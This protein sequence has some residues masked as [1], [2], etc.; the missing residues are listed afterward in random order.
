[1]KKKN[2]SKKGEYEKRKYLFNCKSC[3]KSPKDKTKFVIK[4]FTKSRGVILQCSQC[5]LLISRKLKFLDLQI[6]DEK[7]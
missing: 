4:K 5:G 6:E 1:M 3:S 7:D 2:H